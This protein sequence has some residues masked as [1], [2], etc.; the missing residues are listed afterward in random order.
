MTRDVP[1]AVVKSLQLANK[2][3]VFLAVGLGVFVQMF[4]HRGDSFSVSHNAT[5]NKR[6]TRWREKWRD[7]DRGSHNKNKRAAN[8]RIVDRLV[9]NDTKNL[10]PMSTN[11]TAAT[12]PGFTLVVIDTCVHGGG[13]KGAILCLLA[14]NKKRK[15]DKSIGVLI[16]LL[17][18]PDT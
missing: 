6:Q 13:A 15:N 14:S 7:A 16:A 3:Q 18:P 17:P 1:S 12:T 8:Q 5:K 2:C 11:S 4:S 9:V 10:A